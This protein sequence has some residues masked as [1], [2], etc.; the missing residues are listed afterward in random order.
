MLGST[1]KRKVFV[2][3]SDENEFEALFEVLNG[4]S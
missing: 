4:I 1:G 3:E 2:W